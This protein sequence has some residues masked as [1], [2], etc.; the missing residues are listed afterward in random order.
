MA[1]IGQTVGS[2]INMQLL[3]GNRNWMHLFNRLLSAS[4][5]NTNRF[6]VH[7]MAPSIEKALKGVLF[8]EN[9]WGRGV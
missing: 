8:I 3:L 5:Y 7:T 4:P 2:A 9:H 6:L 1:A